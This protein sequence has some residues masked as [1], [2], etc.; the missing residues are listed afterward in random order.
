MLQVLT[1]NALAVQGSDAETLLETLRSIKTRLDES[2]TSAPVVKNPTLDSEDLAEKWPDDDYRDF[3]NELAEAVDLAERALASEDDG[4]SH[5]LWQ[6]LLGDDFPAGPSD[7]SK[8][9][10]TVV[11]P[12]PAK[13]RPRPKPDGGR[14]YG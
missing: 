7:P 10:G 2:P 3:R 4:E 13:P 1:A 5:D 12:V 11:P 14:T 8:G 9:P 6:E